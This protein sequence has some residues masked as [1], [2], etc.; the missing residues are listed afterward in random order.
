M[1]TFFQFIYLLIV[2]VSPMYEYVTNIRLY[3]EWFVCS[4]VIRQ[5]DQTPFIPRWKP[6]QTSPSLAKQTNH[7]DWLLR[8]QKK[9]N[10]I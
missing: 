3:G 1:A 8:K 6:K 7:H 9:Y 5:R 10:C 4:N 2:H